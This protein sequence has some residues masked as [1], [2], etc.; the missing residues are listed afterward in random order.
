MPAERTRPSPALIVAMIALAAALAGSATALPGKN[1]VDKND[2]RKGAV[3]K[4]ALKKNAVTTK[5]LRDAAVT[6]P[7]IAAHEAP[8]V[9]GAPGEPSFANG[10]EGDCVWRNIS[11]TE[12]FSGT[13]P[14]AFY[15]DQLGFVHMEGFAFAE[16]G[17]GGDGNCDVSDP[18]EEEDG[19]VFAL[20]AGYAPA[21]VA[22][23]GL[24][25]A[26]VAPAS[27]AT[28]EGTPIPGGAVFAGSEFAALEGLDYRPATPA[29][30]SGKPARIDLDA[31]RRLAR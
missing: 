29:A 27:G 5:A 15:R 1:A 22:I 31:L 26:V 28:V 2:L 9:V 12:G 17:T 30:A 19:I 13:N 8:H 7:K 16:D 4:R 14:A 23:G 18:G 25:S 11:A 3:T 21:G 20:P 6:A 10:G 24:L